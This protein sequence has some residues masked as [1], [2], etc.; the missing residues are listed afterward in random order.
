MDDLDKL[1][2][3]I[4]AIH[5]ENVRWLECIMNYTFSMTVAHCLKHLTHDPDSI[6]LIKLIFR[7][8]CNDV[9]EGS[10]R[11]QLSHDVDT[12]LVLISC[13]KLDQIWMVESHQHFDLLVQ[14]LQVLITK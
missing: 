2:C 3:T 13:I 14:V 4:V 8:I 7:S 9:E 5:Q 6:L 10:A 1:I 12:F 11:A